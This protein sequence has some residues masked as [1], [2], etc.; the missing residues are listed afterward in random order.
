MTFVKLTAVAVPPAAWENFPNDRPLTFLAE[1]AEAMRRRMGKGVDVAVQ[2]GLF[3][4][5]ARRLD[6]LALA[7]AES[8]EN[9]FKV[10]WAGSAAEAALHAHS[11]VE[12]QAARVPPPKEPEPAMPVSIWKQMLDWIIG[13]F[14]K[15]VP[16]KEEVQKEVELAKI[17]QLE[18]KTIF[19][20]REVSALAGFYASK[21]VAAWR[22][23]LEASAG[24]E[25]RS[26]AV[27]LTQMR[28]FL[29]RA[30]QDRCAVLLILDLALPKEVA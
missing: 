30:S 15:P 29:A 12:H 16:G 14:R 9:A 1:D 6:A 8:N 7:C 23:E 11:L 3:L 5:L 22:E 27:Y 24:G 13:E 26:I 10:E 21:G 20:P 18:N 17:A 28:D 2:R 4:Q 19:F 25:E